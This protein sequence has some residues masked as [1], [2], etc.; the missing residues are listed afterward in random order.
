M[1]QLVSN[2][3]R[4]AFRLAREGHPVPES[5]LDLFRGCSGSVPIFHPRFVTCRRSEKSARPGVR[6][7]GQA[8]E[9]SEK[10]QR[11]GL[12]SVW[13]GGEEGM[14]VGGG[15]IMSVCLCVLFEGYLVV[16]WTSTRDKYIFM[17]VCYL[18]HT[19]AKTCFFFFFSGFRAQLNDH[20]A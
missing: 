6:V 19:H 10:R 1:V 18:P 7:A 3:K 2:F 16:L 17:E 20:L 8:Q 4:P 14:R 13:M 9:L 5:L 12:E 11:R 15:G